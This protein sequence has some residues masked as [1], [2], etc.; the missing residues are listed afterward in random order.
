VVGLDDWPL[1]KAADAVGALNFSRTAKADGDFAG[2][3]NDGDLAPTVGKLEHARQALL[4]FENVDVLMGN[5][6]ARESL[7]GSSRVGSKIFSEDKN[8]LIHCLVCRF[9][10]PPAAFIKNRRAA[11]KLQVS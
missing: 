8:F 3:D 1:S 2:L 5:F 6:A 4:V 10:I 9:T 11:V 7:P